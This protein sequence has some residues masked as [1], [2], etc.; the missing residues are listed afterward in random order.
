MVLFAF[1]CPVDVKD[2]VY[3]H[4]GHQFQLH[5]RHHVGH[6]VGHLVNLNVHHQHNTIQLCQRRIHQHAGRKNKGIL[7]VG[8]ILHVNLHTW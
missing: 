1:Y 2:E 3:L 7:G 5:V 6:L 4:I 8:Y